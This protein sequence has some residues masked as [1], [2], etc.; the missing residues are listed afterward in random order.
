MWSRPSKTQLHAPLSLG[1]DDSSPLQAA[2]KGRGPVEQ[3]QLGTGVCVCT[4]Y[5]IMAFLRN[6]SYVRSGQWG[7]Y[8]HAK[9]VC[10]T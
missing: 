5:C 8:A 9:A 1:R 4:L 3:V 10:L 7:Q 2:R 6:V